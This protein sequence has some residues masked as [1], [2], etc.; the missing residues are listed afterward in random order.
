MKTLALRPDPGVPVPET[1]MVMGC[2]HCWGVNCLS[3]C[4]LLVY[5]GENGGCHVG[6]NKS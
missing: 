3:C 4:P 6:G 1:A 2:F 5:E